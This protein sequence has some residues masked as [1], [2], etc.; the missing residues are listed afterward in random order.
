MLLDKAYAVSRHW[1][2]A[3]VVICGDFNCTPKVGFAFLMAPV[4]LL[5]DWRQILV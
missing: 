5:A 1:N 3:P 4:F 2:N